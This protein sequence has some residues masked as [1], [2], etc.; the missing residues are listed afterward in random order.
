MANNEY[1]ATQFSGPLVQS[2]VNAQLTE[3]QKFDPVLDFFYNLSIDTAD[4]YW[5]EKIGQW[6]GYTRPLCPAG[7]WDDNSFTYTDLAH[8]G[9]DEL[10]GY[11]SLDPAL[12]GGGVYIS[13]SSSF[14]TKMPIDKYRL[15]LKQFAYIKYNGL[16]LYSLDTLAKVFGDDYK[17]IYDDTD[18]YFRYTDLSHAGDSISSGYGS[19]TLGTGGGAYYSA[20]GVASDIY[21]VYNTNIGAGNVFLIQNVLDHFTTAPQVF[22]VIGG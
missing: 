5:L 17:F 1:L 21:L 12:A 10:T 6:I 18:Y 19:L 14:A 15:A 3:W 7:I 11:G 13:S 9:N 2:T 16:T 8:Q 4:E 22:V 20:S